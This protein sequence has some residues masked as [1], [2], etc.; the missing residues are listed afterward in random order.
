MKPEIREIAQVPM[1]K[2]ISLRGGVQRKR[3]KTSKRHARCY[4]ALLLT[5]F[6]LT[7]A[8]GCSYQ[9]QRTTAPPNGK[10]S[11]QA[12][13]GER[14]KK[15]A[16][17]NAGLSGHKV[18]VLNPADRSVVAS[19]TTKGAGFVDFDVPPGTYSLVGASD[20]PQIVQVQPGQ[21]ANFKLVVH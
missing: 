8:S 6:L 16:E 21:T 5:L 19:G 12:V 14:A 3:H 1:P 4:G 13:S 7:N 9:K 15:L 11:V 20:E 10:I 2:R 17:P 18:T